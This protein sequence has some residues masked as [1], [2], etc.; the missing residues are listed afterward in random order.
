MVTATVK[1]MGCEHL[2]Y[3]PPPRPSQSIREGTKQTVQKD[4]LAYVW[5][6]GIITLKM[7]YF[8]ETFGKC[9]N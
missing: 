5:A 9:Q 1:F 4:H 3:Q 7:T 6:V 8:S 2:L